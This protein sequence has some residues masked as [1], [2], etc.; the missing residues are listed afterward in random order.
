ML[1]KV[2]SDIAIMIAY[3]S[4]LN[5]NLEICSFIILIFRSQQMTFM[6]TF[7]SQ[8]ICISSRDYKTQQAVWITQCVIMIPWYMIQKG[9]D[10]FLLWHVCVVCVCVF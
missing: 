5:P 1:N 4:L 9:F 7:V 8:V 10:L 2:N 3:I 6:N